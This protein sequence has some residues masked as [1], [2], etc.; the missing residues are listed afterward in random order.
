MDIRRMIALGVLGKKVDVQDTPLVLTAT[1]TG[2]A[3]L[4]IQDLTIATGKSVVVDWGDGNTNTYTAGGGTRSH[5]YAGAGT[6][7]IKIANRSSITSI[8]LQQETKLSGTINASN[9]WPSGLKYLIL[10]GIPSLTYNGS[11]TPLPSGLLQLSLTTMA[12]F[13]YNANTYPLSSTLTSLTL[14][15][16]ANFTYNINDNPLP[17]GLTFLSLI[18]SLPGLT[19]NV[20]TTALPTGLLSLIVNTLTSGNFTFDGTN[21][22]PDS[23]TLINMYNL[24]GFTYNVNTNPWPAGLITLTLN[25]LSGLTWAADAGSPIPS[26]VTDL[27]IYSCNNISI[28]AAQWAVN[29]LQHII[30]QSTLTA[31]EVDDI[32]LGVWTNKANYTHATPTLNL[33]GTNNHSPTGTFQAGSGESGLPTTGMEYAYD[34]KNGTYTSAGAE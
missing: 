7:A 1:L 14:Y 17:S 24:A 4:W 3:T 25:T 31:E 10:N 27:T 11:T 15:N 12:G 26:T 6:Y 18:G 16:V 8:N 21:P 13:T 23:L 33:L 9:P 19:Y 2:A 30:F 22:L 29:G 5:A 32:L 20:N 28:P 34:L